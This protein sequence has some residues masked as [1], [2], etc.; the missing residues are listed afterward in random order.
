M[1]KETKVKR[2]TNIKRDCPAGKRLNPTTNRCI[3]IKKCPD[4][5]ILDLITNKCVKKPL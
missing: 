4:G 2:E 1:V 3:V 5:K